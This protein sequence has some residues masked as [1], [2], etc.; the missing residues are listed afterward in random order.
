MSDAA[1]A[2]APEVKQQP[3]RPRKRKFQNELEATLHAAH[4]G[5]TDEKGFLTNP[6][7]VQPGDYVS[8]TMFYQVTDRKPGETT[9]ATADKRRTVSV[10]GDGV[11]SNEFY[12]SKAISEKK[13]CRSVIAA[14]LRSAKDA[15]I[16]VKFLKK[17]ETKAQDGL[18]KEIAEGK[19]ETRTKRQRLDLVKRLTQG[20]ER[21]LIGRVLGTDEINAG[22]TT[23]ID[24]A[25]DPNAHR[26]RLVDHRSILSVVYK[27][28]RY[29]NTSK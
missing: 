16:E 4:D 21:T 24:L 5:A 18:V 12:T 13:V 6:T 15:V 9:L 17:C 27:N 23:M 19:H 2:K 26:V 7:S 11:L 10:V 20:P 1:E 3:D 8:C 14:I 29:V 22:R 25:V 28:V